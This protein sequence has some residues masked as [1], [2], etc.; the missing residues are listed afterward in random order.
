MCFERLV[1]ARVSGKR[2]GTSAGEQILGARGP[3]CEGRFLG[4]IQGGRKAHGM[5]GRDIGGR[6]HGGR[7]P[8]RPS[9]KDSYITKFVHRDKVG[10]TSPR[11]SPSP[12]PFFSSLSLSLS[13]FSS[14]VGQRILRLFS[15]LIFRGNEDRN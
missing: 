2:D 7:V 5:E 12:L 1:G 10:I 11:S 6:D 14:K 8:G 4:A 9:D 13:L 3:L 15:V